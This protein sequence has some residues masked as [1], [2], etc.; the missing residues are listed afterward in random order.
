MLKK[1]NILLY[2][3]YDTMLS[4]MVLINGKVTMA[5]I[6]KSRPFT[7]KSLCKKIFK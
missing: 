4:E 7:L 6:K 5:D 2:N 1:R 3:I